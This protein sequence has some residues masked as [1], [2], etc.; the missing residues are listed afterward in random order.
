MITARNL[1][2]KRNGR[3]KALRLEHV[4]K[5]LESS[6]FAVTEAKVYVYL[7]KKG[8]QTLTEI[9]HGLGMSKQRLSP[10]L[11]SLREKSAVASN[12]KPTT[13]FSALSIEKVIDIQVNKTVNQ[14]KSIKKAKQELLASWRN[15]ETQKNT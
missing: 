8:P 6:G 2:F 15:L 7:A 11:S 13:Q 9:T 14:A 1:T 3:I 4:L 12:F 5:I 10:I